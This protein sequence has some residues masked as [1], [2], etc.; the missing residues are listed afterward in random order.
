MGEVI[1]ED[2]HCQNFN[3]DKESYGSLIS[4]HILHTGSVQGNAEAGIV[5][6]QSL[7]LF[8][9]LPQIKNAHKKHNDGKPPIGYQ[10]F[11]APMY[12]YLICL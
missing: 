1:N 8:K 4:P 12:H 2:K 5:T 7:F 3:C 9:V 6:F 11:P 10:M